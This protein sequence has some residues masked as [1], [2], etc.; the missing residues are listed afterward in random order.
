MRGRQVREL[1]LP[2]PPARMPPLRALRPL[3]RWRYVAVYRPD[4]MLCMGHARV[5]GIPQ[6]WWAVAEPDGSLHEGSR[7]V[8]LT[9]GRARVRDGET[10]IEL[11]LDEGEGVEVASRH[12]RSYIWTRKQAGLAVRA[13]VAVAG[14]RWELAGDE[15]FIDDSAGYHARRTRW[16]WSAGVG[17]GEGGEQ[18][19]WNLVEGLHDAPEAS[20]R[21]VW[22][23]GRPREAE[24]QRFAADLSAVGEPG[25]PGLER[26]A[27]ADQPPARSQRL[28]PALRRL[29]GRAAGRDT[30]GGGVRCH[31][32][33]RRPV[34]TPGRRSAGIY[35]RR[36]LAALAALALALL[37]VVLVVRGLAGGD[38][39]SGGGG[40]SP[41]NAEDEDAPEQ[42]TV[43][44]TVAASGD[45]LIHSPVFYRALEYGGGD[46]ATTSGRC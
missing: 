32:M 35:W 29:L 39:G 27:R 30:P 28:P 15:G 11:E 7:G 38:D 43:R 14:R 13:R 17:R 31:G 2:L 36:R 42:P 16:R 23:D 22:V 3:K 21:T 44:F 37:A 45:L 18:L 26:A 10:E 19:A 5:A 4:L 9:P 41:E 20:E 6:R 12:G 25:L 33:A 40:G 34:V 24:P 46:P 1:A 8:E